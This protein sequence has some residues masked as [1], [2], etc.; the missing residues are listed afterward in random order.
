MKLLTEMFPFVCVVKLSV[1]SWRLY[2]SVSNKASKSGV[3]KKNEPGC[4]VWP[5]PLE[6]IFVDPPRTRTYASVVLCFSVLYGWLGY[7]LLIC[8]P[9]NIYGAEF[10][11]VITLWFPLI[12]W[13][14]PVHGLVAVH[15]CWKWSF[16]HDLVALHLDFCSLSFSKF[17]LTFSGSPITL[18]FFHLHRL[19]TL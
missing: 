5:F 13:Y 7:I 11:A 19:C 16:P 2:M 10:M 14:F 15:Q 6:I 4:K 12:N 9:A 8:F 3:V 18:F 17:P 1:L